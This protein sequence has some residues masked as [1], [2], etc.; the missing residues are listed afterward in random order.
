[1]AHV[2]PAWVV[3]ITSPVTDPPHIRAFEEAIADMLQGKSVGYA[4]SG[5]NM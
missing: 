3:E 2:D 1:V 5:L 4:M